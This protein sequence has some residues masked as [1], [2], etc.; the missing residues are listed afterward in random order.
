[1]TLLHFSLNHACVRTLEDY[2]ASKLHHFC[3]NLGGG[4]G[5]GESEDCP[6]VTLSS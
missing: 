5:G 1:M 4:G 6:E 2:I 3:N